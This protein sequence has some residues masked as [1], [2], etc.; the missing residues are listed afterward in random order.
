MAYTNHRRLQD[1]N[2]TPWKKNNFL[3]G[4]NYM[5]SFAKRQRME[6]QTQESDS[7]RPKLASLLEKLNER[8]MVVWMWARSA[9]QSSSLN[10]IYLPSHW[11]S[12]ASPG[13]PCGDGGAESGSGGLATSEEGGL[14]AYSLLL[15]HQIGHCLLGEMGEERETISL[16][17]MEVPSVLWKWEKKG[18]A[19]C[20]NTMQILTRLI[21][22][23]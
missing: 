9:S 1:G 21:S 15:S 13:L 7:W 5:L 4:N 11:H 16:W 3:G 8:E 22:I 18:I 2:I 6:K 10:W 14:R 19:F 12:W 20:T 23:F 17:G